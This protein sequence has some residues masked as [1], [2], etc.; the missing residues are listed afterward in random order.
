PAVP[1]TIYYAHKQAEADS[2]AGTSSTGWETFLEAVN[3]AG[4]AVTGTWPMR[5]EVDNRQVGIG[6]NALASSVIL[7]CR[8]R[9]ETATTTSG[10]AF[11]RDLNAVLPVALDEMTRGAGDDQSP[12]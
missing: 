3:R 7:V 1:V 11:A 8:R 10:R 2:G 6:S 9:L 12:V 4:L 5:T